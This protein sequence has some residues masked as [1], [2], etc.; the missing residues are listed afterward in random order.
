M[1]RFAVG[2]VV[3]ALLASCTGDSPPQPTPSHAPT[4]SVSSIRTADDLA[5]AIRRA[6]GQLKE[7]GTTFGIP[8][9]GATSNLQCTFQGKFVA[10]LSF[11]TA[12]STPTSAAGLR[13]RTVVFGPTWIV[14]AEALAQGRAIQTI[15]GGRLVLMPALTAEPAV[16]LFPPKPHSAKVTFRLGVRNPM[17][18][19]AT[20]VCSTRGLS[21]EDKILF[22][23]DGSEA[24]DLRRSFDA[25][26][27]SSLTAEVPFDQP[28]M[29]T[30]IVAWCLARPAT[31]PRQSNG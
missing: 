16:K 2:V 29:V 26:E 21:A 10:L 19:P 31:Q 9:L 30:K 25:H 22:R 3:S 18:R 20:V 23:E 28:A 14:I 7:C 11:E 12:A 13:D 15:T 4:Q 5:R 27:R 1:R 17:D 6:T 8:P 24:D